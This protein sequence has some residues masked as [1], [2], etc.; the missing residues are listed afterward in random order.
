MNATKKLVISLIFFVAASVFS[1]SALVKERTPNNENPTNAELILYFGSTCPHCKLVEEYIQTNG[2]NS[3]LTIA[4]KEIYSN[5]GNKNELIEKATECGL[6]Q[7]KL[8]VPMLWDSKTGKCYGGQTDKGSDE[9]I[10]YL[11]QFIISK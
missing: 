3:K 11:S 9:V 7:K 1:I 5:S 10:A 2:L 6:D 8:A 4:Q